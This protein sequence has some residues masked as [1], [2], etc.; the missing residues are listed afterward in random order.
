ME[1]IMKR[2]MFRLVAA[3]LFTVAL[4]C[5]SSSA[6]TYTPIAFPGARSTNPQGINS[7]DEVVGWFYDANRVWHG[8]LLTNGQYTQLDFP[9]ALN[10]FALGINDNGEIVGYYDDS[11]LVTHGF[12]LINGQFTSIDYPGAFAIS[13]NGVNNAGQIVGFYTDGQD[14]RTRGYRLDGQVFTVIEIPYANAAETLAF[15]INTA[16][17]IVGTYMDIYY[18]TFGFEWHAGQFRKVAFPRGTNTSPQG[19]N[20]KGQI[21]GFFTGPAAQEGFVLSHG[22][23]AAVQAPG[24]I[25]TFIYG[26]N[27]NGAIVGYSIDQN[28]VQTGFMVTR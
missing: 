17:D 28:L 18:R 14:N 2:G 1:E 9:G 26:M 13:A 12:Y 3:L 11:N 21:V 23:H 8:F 4:C 25:E 20:D 19:I 22:S 16:G 6:L 10:S 7:S 15:G 27:N 5:A 24:A